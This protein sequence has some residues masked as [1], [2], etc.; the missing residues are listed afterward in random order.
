MQRN[1]LI[2]MPVKYREVDLSHMFTYD[3]LHMSHTT[4]TCMRT[5]KW[6]DLQMCTVAISRIVNQRFK[7]LDQMRQHVG[8]IRLM[9]L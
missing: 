6:L 3:M 7:Q 9:A 1:V 2:L 5:R 8:V 4:T